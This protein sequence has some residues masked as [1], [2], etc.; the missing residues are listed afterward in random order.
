MLTFRR[1]YENRSVGP[2]S[3]V[4]YD[5]F[6]GD[7]RVGRLLHHPQGPEGQPWFWSIEAGDP[8]NTNNCGY[9]ASRERALAECETRLDAH[10]MAKILAA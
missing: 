5:V 3:D 2:W 1:I 9:A 8:Q 4:D 7:Q 10:R 6:R